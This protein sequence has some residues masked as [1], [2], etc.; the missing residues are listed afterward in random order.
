MRALLECRGLTVRFGGVTA[1]DGVDL[2]V[3]EGRIVGIIGPNGAG[4]STTLNVVSGY[5]RPNA[6]CVRLAGRDLQTDSPRRRAL[7]GLGRTFQTARPFAGLSVRENLE[8][9]QYQ[10]ARRC[11]FG[12]VSEVLAECGLVAVAGADAS[13]LTAGDR[14]F[15]ELARALMLDPSLLLLDEPTTGLRDHE[16]DRLGGLLTR[17][18]TEWGIGGLVVSH[19]MRL[20]AD[21]CERV[22]AFDFGAVMAEGTPAEI[23]S[24]AAVVRTYLGDRHVA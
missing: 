21:V 9:V 4:K 1:L 20:I 18:R 22:V 11:R 19:D 5:V 23:R 6:G 3:E 17:L 24:D 13:R 7:L 2:T 8:I 12:S 14:R 16:V 15:V 10:A